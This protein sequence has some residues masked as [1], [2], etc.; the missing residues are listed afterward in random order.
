MP[1]PVLLLLVGAA[2]A[3]EPSSGIPP[4][5]WDPVVDTSVTITTGVTFL[6]LNYLIEP[7]LP[8]V[9]PTPE[10]VPAIDEVAVGRWNPTAA[11]ASDGVVYGTTA[12][13]VLAAGFCGDGLQGRATSVGLVAESLAVTGTSIGVLKHA[14]D[15]PRPYTMMEDPPADVQEKLEDVDSWLSFPSGHT[16]LTAAAS[17]SVAGVL[18]AEGAPPGPVYAAAGVLTVTAGTLRVVAGRHYPTDVLVGG[19]VGTTVG[20]AVPALHATHPRG[21]RGGRDVSV[22]TSTP[23]EGATL[24]GLTAPW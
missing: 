15:R 16:G 12:L 4:F 20:L 10:D 19:L 9:G 1:G 17:F 6:L 11:H 7:T 18:A 2:L 21:R 24:V 14:V 23:G 22:W 3:R 5:R 8:A 13:S